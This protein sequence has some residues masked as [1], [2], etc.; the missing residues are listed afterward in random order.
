LRYITS[1]KLRK[2]GEWEA[3]QQIRPL[4][5]AFACWIVHY[6]LFVRHS[7]SLS[8]GIASESLEALLQ[9]DS[10]ALFSV[11]RFPNNAI[12]T[13]PNLLANIE[14]PQYPLINHICHFSAL[15]QHK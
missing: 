2:N 6:S 3:A 12:G 14:T 13:L 7:R 9:R 15:W 5:Q 8:I 10:A 4:D 11:H 1:R